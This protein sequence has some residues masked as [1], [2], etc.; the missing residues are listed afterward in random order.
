MVTHRSPDDGRLYDDDT[1]L[2]DIPGGHLRSVPTIRPDDVWVA[3]AIGAYD[4]YED[5]PAR[6]RP[7]SEDKTVADLEQPFIVRRH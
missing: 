3:G 4:R 7:H 2:P 5:L 1:S 6:C